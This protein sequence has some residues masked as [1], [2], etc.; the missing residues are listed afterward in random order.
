MS[1]LIQFPKRLTRLSQR[2]QFE[3]LSPLKS[4]KTLAAVVRKAGGAFRL[5]ADDLADEA[6][7]VEVVYVKEDNEWEIR[8]KK[9]EGP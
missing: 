7:Q 3:A 5:T 1:D 2:Q 4:P 6:G 8:L 9:E